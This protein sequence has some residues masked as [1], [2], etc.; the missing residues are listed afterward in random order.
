[1]QKEILYNKKKLA[2]SVHGTEN[3][4]VVV[5]LHG[6]GEDSRIWQNQIEKL[7]DFHLII[8]DI[9]GSGHSEIIDDMSM[10]GLA[11]AIFQIV[12]QERS[13][14]LSPHFTLIGHS[15]GGYITLAFAEKYPE[16]LKGFGL[17]H[18]TAY[19]DNEEKIR[20]RRKGIEFIKT[21][22]PYEFLKTAI[23][24]LYSPLTRHKNP[25]LIE[26][27]LNSVHNF[28]EAALVMYYESMIKRP[29]RVNLL[30]NSDIPVLFILGKYDTAVPLKDGLEQCFLPSLSYIHVL[31]ESGH[32]G[33][34]EEKEKTNDILQNYL[35]SIEHQTP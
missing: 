29:D 2:Y 14:T 16:M 5:L 33:M 1:M 6:F 30:K 26:E 9:P 20:T 28:S 25:S 34:I 19:A 35:L 32:M 27:H 31:D 23:P 22:G 8:P 4:P 17:F 3:G 10:E 11:D 18:S 15:M 12:T 7:K 24:N 21:H 13:R